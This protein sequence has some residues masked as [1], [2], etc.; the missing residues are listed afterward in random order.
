MTQDWR[1][2]CDL[3]A[4]LLEQEVSIYRQLIMELKK[5]SKHLRQGE[6][7]SILNSVKTVA[8]RV[9]TIQILEEEIRK[10]GE[11]ILTG[12]GKG[13]RNHT[14]SSL[15]PFL[16]TAQQGRLSSSQKI[17]LQLKGWAA[18]INE[19]NRAFIR[20]YMTFLSELI[21][22][23]FGHTKDSEGYP[24]RKRPPAFPAY[25]LNREV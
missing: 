5:Q 15:L 19:Q 18:Q 23:W 4:Q 11:T 21:S 12:F 13:E 16:P 14:L 2:E 24:G 7:D 6:T 17:L 22:P 9:K 20:E 8:E 25:A 3:L 10:T 1:R